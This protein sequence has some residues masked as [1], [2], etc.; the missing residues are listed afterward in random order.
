MSENKDYL[1]GANEAEL[2]RLEFQ[3]KV[4]KNVTDSFLDRI[5]IKENWKCLDVGAGPGFVTD[6]LRNRLDE[7]GE[8]TALEPSE[9]YLNYYREKCRKSEL[10]NVK[11]IQGNA[12]DTELEK[13][14]YDFIFL[15]WVIDFVKEPEKFLLK[16]TDCLKSG[17]TIAIQDYAYEGIALFPKGGKFDNIAEVV[18]NYWKSGGGDPYF[19][20]KIPYIFKKNNIELTEYSPSSLA[21]GNDSD[22]FEWAN[23]FFNIH[24]QI[25]ADSKLITQNDCD[26][27]LKDW[28]DHRQN[29]ETVFFSPVIVNISGKKLQR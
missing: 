21:G 26:E 15:R 8:V 9:Y 23:K 29:S 24:L 17:G 18:K 16:L 5:G 20:T 4:W 7:T 1:L 6:D 25:M 3:H 22:I 19:T 14:H 2:Y 10:K 13:N 11:F 28:N 12:E 27:L